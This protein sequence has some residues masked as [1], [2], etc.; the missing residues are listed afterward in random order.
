MRRILLAALAS[1]AMATMAHAGVVSLNFE[2]INATYPSG[3]A[4]VNGFYDGGVSSDGTS[5]TN[6]GVTFSANAQAICLNS[7]SVV[8]SNTS[9]GGLAPG[10]DKGAL[11]FL[12]GTSTTIDVAAGFTTGFSFNYTNP[13]G[14]AS[15]VQVWSGVDGTGTELANFALASTPNGDTACPGYSAAFCPFVPIG[16]TFSGTAHSIV[17]GGVANEV[18]MDDVTFGSSSPGVPEPATWA[19]MLAGLAGAGAML[20]RRRALAVA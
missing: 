18:V 15:S 19:T 6:Y 9:R 7:L 4:F 12:S 8:C 16:V 20:R 13:T 2:G 5:G 17:F 10:S 11:F 1:T 14:F 3:Y